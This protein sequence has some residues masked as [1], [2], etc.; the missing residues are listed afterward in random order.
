[1]A[2]IDPW[3]AGAITNYDHVFK[4]FGLKPF[5]SEWNARFKSPLFRRN[6]VI[7]HRDFD[8]VIARIGAKK[9]FAQL[10]GIA[11]SGPYHL[12]HKVDVDLFLALK[13]AGAKCFF[14]RRRSRR[15]SV[16]A[17]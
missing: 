4:E 13:K 16:A 17:R 10:T 7:A 12:G 6:V 14:L 8:K 9:P 2:V 3:G 15:L 11:S 5:P 1:M